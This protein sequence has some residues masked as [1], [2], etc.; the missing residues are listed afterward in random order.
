M[1]LD[2]PKE[3]LFYLV[4]GLFNINIQL[5]LLGG[6]Y[7]DPFNSLKEYCQASLRP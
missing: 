7:L 5:Y 6:K 3:N 1:Y 4:S 2:P